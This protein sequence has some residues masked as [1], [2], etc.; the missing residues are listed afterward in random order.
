MSSTGLSPV[1]TDHQCENALLALTAAEAFIG[2]AIPASSVNEALVNTRV[3]GR[4][5]VVHANPTVVRDGAHNPAGAAAL[6]LAADEVFAGTTPRILLCGT[7]AGRDPV[8]FVDQVGIQDFDF[9]VATMPG[10]PRALS[11]LQC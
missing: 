10:S 3:P 9:V 5:E 4:F 2:T 7:L 11:P 6:R 8:E 1:V